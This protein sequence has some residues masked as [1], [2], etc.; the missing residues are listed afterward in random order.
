MRLDPSCAVHL[1]LANF[2]VM[3]INTSSS[4]EPCTKRNG[5]KVDNDPG[6][7][8]T[9]ILA[10]FV[11]GVE[12]D[13]RGRRVSIRA[14]RNNKSSEEM[15]TYSPNDM[16]TVV[17]WHGDTVSVDPR[18]QLLGQ[19]DD[20]DIDDNEGYKEE[21]H[22][23]GTEHGNRSLSG[24]TDSGHTQEKSEPPKEET[25]RI[26]VVCVKVD[27]KG[28]VDH[29]EEERYGEIETDRGNK[30]V[31]DV[32]SSGEERSNDFADSVVGHRHDES[33]DEHVNKT[34]ESNS[35]SDGLVVRPKV[36]HRIPYSVGDCR[37][38]LSNE[39]ESSGIVG[40]GLEV[41][42]C[43]PSIV[44]ERKLA[45]SLLDERNEIGVESSFLPSL[46]IENLDDRRSAPARVTVFSSR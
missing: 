17:K 34:D 22:K 14:T 31:D 28:Q 21:S 25:A 35:L 42:S 6:N 19:A 11:L 37:R 20:G 10:D 18:L 40:V 7:E 41:G 39:A 32:S 33:E 26:S 3:L 4:E 5:D 2:L 13:L 45:Q 29:A 9:H 44:L 27:F 8:D 24:E 23:F 46:C 38:R 36:I 43:A 1:V 16:A 15:E 30:S 12:D